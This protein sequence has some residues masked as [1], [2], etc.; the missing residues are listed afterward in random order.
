MSTHN[1]CFPGEIRKVLSGYPLSGPMQ[2]MLNLTS[3]MLITTAA[4]NNLIVFWG[5]FF[6][7]FLYFFM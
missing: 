4:E 7:I 6:C 2:P 5:F 3:K 1:I